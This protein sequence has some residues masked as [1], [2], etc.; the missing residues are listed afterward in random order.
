[1]TVVLPFVVAGGVA[2][3]S[4]LTSVMRYP[5]LWPV[6]A[7]RQRA[8]RNLPFL[9]VPSDVAH[10]ELEAG[11]GGVAHSLLLSFCGQRRVR[12]PGQCCWAE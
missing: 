2:S 5:D 7:L 6:H 8:R 11:L 4:V 3:Q 1:M 10:G 12:I 9:Q